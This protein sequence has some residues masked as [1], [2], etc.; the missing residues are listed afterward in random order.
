MNVLVR[1]A[2]IVST[3]AL[4]SVGTAG[5]AS[6]QNK[7]SG[8]GAC[9]DPQDCSGQ[10]MQ[11]SDEGEEGNSSKRRNKADQSDAEDQVSDEQ[12]RRERR[13][14]ENLNGS[15]P[16]VSDD[17]SIKRRKQAQSDWRF[18]SKK[19]ERRRKRDNHYRFEFGGYWYP[20][21]YWYGY[22]YGM[23]YRIS[24]RDGRELLVDRGFRRVRTIEC[25]G[26][27]FTYLGR[28]HGDNFRVLV[29]SRTGRI[30]SVRSV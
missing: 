11:K 5:I 28:R 26:R 29:N 23:N 3:I 27:T 14:Q 18:D 6:S 15:E 30:V 19:H 10:Q 16:Q 9:D 21:S 12:S 2:A 7:H 24:C 8:Q 22:G 13:I 4:M 20:E 1:N 17:Q 25:Q